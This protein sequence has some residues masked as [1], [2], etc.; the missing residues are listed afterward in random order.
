[1]MTSEPTPAEAHVDTLAARWEANRAGCEAFY[2]EN[3]TWPYGSS[4]DPGER[5]L[6]DWLLRMRTQSRR[7]SLPADQ[8]AALDAMSLRVGYDWTIPRHLPSPA[9]AVD[10]PDPWAERLAAVETFYRAH[11]QWPRGGAEDPTES[12]LGWWM[13]RQRQPVTGTLS[14]AHA[15]A[16]DEMSRRVGH[17]WRTP[18]RDP[19]WQ[20]PH[21]T[22]SL[23]AEAAA[24][25]KAF[26]DRRWETKRATL[27]SFH[28]RMG[29]WPRRGASDEVEHALASWHTTQRYMHRRGDLSPERL[30]A[31]EQMS[32]R[33]HADWKPLR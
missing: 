7:G 1:M 11:R 15:A 25:R 19:D 10:R 32:K 9:P 27:E 2:V 24:G 5:R 23:S 8:R 28:R 30:D 3:G 13:G 31:L 12:E 4:N 18:P 17:D 6:G 29:R 14:E 16:L 26:M 22:H 33:L 21:R 20:P